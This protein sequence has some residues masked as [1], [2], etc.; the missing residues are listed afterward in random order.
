M[1]DWDDLRHFAALADEGSLS[2]AARRLGVEHATVARRVSALEA[3]AGAK[4]VDRRSGRYVLT[5]AGEALAAHA[6]RMQDEAFAAERALRVGSQDLAVELSLSAPP[7]ISI[8]LIAPRLA[9]L[10]RLHPHLR[11][12]LLGDVRNVSLS[13]LDADMAVRLVRPDDP[14]LVGRRLASIRYALYATAEYLAAHAEADWEFIA[15][16]QSLDHVAQ[17]AMLK[18]IAGSRPIV[19]RT[20]ELMAQLAAVR[21]HAGIAALPAFAGDG[22]VEVSGRAIERDVWLIYHRDLRG[23]PAITAVSA[24]VG[25]CMP[26]A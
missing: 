1:L 19:I 9:E 10:R 22:L 12:R 16:D 26:K 17:Q 3:A 4:L 15:F 11:L 6:H 20:N 24:F 25:E 2:A 18:E 21:C 14:S 13:R 23:T 5:P 7:M 8:L